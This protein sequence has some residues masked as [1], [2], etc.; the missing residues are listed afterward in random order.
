MTTV[1]ISVNNL[2]T[3][4]TEAPSGPYT[5]LEMEVGPNPNPQ[6]PRCYV[7]SFRVISWKF[8]DFKINP[9]KPVNP[10]TTKGGSKNIKL[11][12]RN[13]LWYAQDDN[14]RILES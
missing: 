3:N 13:V 6:Y 7:L 11:I 2:E 14:L 4:F 9:I 1:V 10:I 5:S 12:T 8:E